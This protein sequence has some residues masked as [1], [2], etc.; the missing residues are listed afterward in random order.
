MAAKEIA[1]GEVI[2]KYGQPIGYAKTLINAGDH[3]HT[4][5]IMYRDVERIYNFS[6]RIKV[7]QFQPLDLISM[8]IKDVMGVLEQEIL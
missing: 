3:L 7:L 1:E 2:I 6:T 8:V 4:H 5:N